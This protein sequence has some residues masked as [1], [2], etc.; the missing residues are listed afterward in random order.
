MAIPL[1]RVSLFSESLGRHVPRST[2]RSLPGAPAGWA[3][4]A[5][6]AAHSSA[7][8]PAA[9]SPTPEGGSSPPWRR[10]AA[11][12][13]KRWA[14]WQSH[15]CPRL[16]HGAALPSCVAHG[17]L[18]WL[19]RQLHGAVSLAAPG[20]RPFSFRSGSVKPWHPFHLPL[21]PHLR[22]PSWKTA[23]V[24]R[25]TC[26]LVRQHMRN[27]LLPRRGSPRAQRLMGQIV[28][29]RDRMRPDDHV[30]IVLLRDEVGEGL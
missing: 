17:W 7:P 18:P 15:R 24:I 16:C 20:E 26:R 14:R 5:D 4:L 2:Y 12:P 9:T 1:E 19:V 21:S 10:P 30:Q 3:R 25:Q 8:P 28:V 27:P 29:L 11:A 13:V 6:F 23:S 22:F